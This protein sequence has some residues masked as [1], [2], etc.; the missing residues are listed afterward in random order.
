MT[1]QAANSAASGQEEKERQK[2]L[3]KKKDARAAT[4]AT[5]EL[6]FVFLPF[7]VIAIT[8]AHQGD[9]RSIFFIPEWSIVS[10]VISG[11]SIAK[12]TYATLGRS[13]V[14]RE[15]IVLVIS[16]VLVGLLVPILIVL[17]IALTSPNVS[18]TLAVTQATFFVLS[19]ALFWFVCWTDSY[20][21]N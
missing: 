18:V 15:V 1:T 20:A 13:N 2:R 4:S 7:I 9:L 17:A 6:L 21:K 8:M 16:L 19:V 11:Q 5:S 10:A 3:D 12:L 14:K